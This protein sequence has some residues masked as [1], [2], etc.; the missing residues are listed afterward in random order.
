VQNRMIA[1]SWDEIKQI[2]D[3][4][5]VACGQ[6]KIETIRGGLLTGVIHHLITDQETAMAV[7]QSAENHPS[8]FQPD[9]GEEF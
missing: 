9:T 3:V 6:D 2:K 5:A 4:L 8:G 1:I 7:L